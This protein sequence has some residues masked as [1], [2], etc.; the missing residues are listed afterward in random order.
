MCRWKNTP[1]LAVDLPPTRTPSTPS[2]LTSELKCPASSSSDSGARQRRHMALGWSICTQ[3]V[4]REGGRRLLG[5]RRAQ[6]RRQT[7]AAWLA[8]SHG[9]RRQAAKCARPPAARKP[10]RAGR[11][12]AHP[13]H[14]HLLLV[15]VVGDH[16]F[17]PAHA[18]GALLRQALQ[19]AARGQ[20]PQPP[21]VVELDVGAARG[22]VE[23]AV[24]RQ[25]QERIETLQLVEPALAEACAR[26]ADAAEGAARGVLRGAAAGAVRPAGALRSPRMRPTLLY[27]ALERAA[28][29]RLT[30][31]VVHCAH[32]TSF[33]RPP[34]RSQHVRSLKKA[35]KTLPTLPDH[36]S[37]AG[38][39]SPEETHQPYRNRYDDMIL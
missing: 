32:A 29:V 21:S 33:D 27:V 15:P 39:R 14:P 23:D 4:R 11:V 16:A 1:L 19:L 34:R 3:G 28:A 36:W 10:A 8:G 17:R 7:V 5:Q 37:T 20:Q 35:T 22:E 6:L 9:S 31:N 18:L 25:K 24:R 2:R 38:W 26:Q 30:V 12:V 13:M